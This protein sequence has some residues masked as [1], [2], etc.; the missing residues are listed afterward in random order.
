MSHYLRK[1]VIVLAAVLMTATACGTSEGSND[2]ES[3]DS[4]ESFSG[5]SEIVIGASVAKTGGQTF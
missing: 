2:S 1:P 3:K 4:G 5:L